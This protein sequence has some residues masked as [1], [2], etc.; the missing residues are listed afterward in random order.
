MTDNKVGIKKAKEWLA[1]AEEDMN[2]AK[3]IYSDVKNPSYRLIAF[4]AQQCAEK[5][6]KGYLI[7]KNI[8]FPYSHNIEKLLRLCDGLAK[9][10]SE[11]NS[12]FLLTKF[13]ITTRFPGLNKTVTKKEAENAIK[14][15]EKVRD[16]VRTAITKEGFEL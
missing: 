6:L 13:A 7:F 4:L 1:L 3:S 16:T 12:S 2:M 11:L 15:A 10:S 14:I 8:D 5:Y 9:N